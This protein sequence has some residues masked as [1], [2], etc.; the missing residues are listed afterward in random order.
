MQHEVTRRGLFHKPLKTVIKH[1]HLI[2]INLQNWQ[3][4]WINLLFQIKMSA[5]SSEGAIVDFNKI[6]P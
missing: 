1:K 5:S 3:K 6:R 4:E 2:D